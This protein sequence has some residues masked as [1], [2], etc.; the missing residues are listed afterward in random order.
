MKSYP[1]ALSVSVRLLTGL[2]FLGAGIVHAQE[3]DGVAFAREVTAVAAI[4]SCDDHARI[5]TGY[6][7]ERAS[8]DGV[9]VVDV[10]LRVRRLAEGRHG[11]HIHET[12]ECM[13]CSAARGHFDPGPYGNS[14]PDANHPFHAGE[15]Q[16]IEVRE[17]GR[18]MLFTVTTRVTLSDGPLSLFDEDG[19]A[20]IIHLDP[21]TYC[22][23]G[24]T[25]GCAGG[26][27]A[28]CGVIV[29]DT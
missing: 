1:V 10:M 4:V 18:G 8:N 28:A 7:R 17:N 22:P 5:G 21:D 3:D 6:L 29:R 25:A 12:G 20:F 13:P 2:A 23:E 26:G 15:L 16:N 24:E 19:S 14:N 27:R 11:V 9:K